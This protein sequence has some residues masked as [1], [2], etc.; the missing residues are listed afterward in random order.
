MNVVEAHVIRAVGKGSF[1]K[2]MSNVKKPYYG[3]LRSII[4]NIIINDS[5]SLGLAQSYLK[6]LGRMIDDQYLLQKE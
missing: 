1:N 2:T 3:E 6:A 4:G 5:K